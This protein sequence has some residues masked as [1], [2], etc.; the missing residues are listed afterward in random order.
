MAFDM[1]TNTLR[2]GQA[3]LLLK[4]FIQIDECFSFTYN[5]NYNTACKHYLFI[6]KTVH[7][8]IFLR[9][10]QLGDTLKYLNWLKVPN[11]DVLN[12]K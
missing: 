8:Q 3:C 7:H 10:L 5:L 4:I 1:I 6:F 12:P 2:L 11:I 9:G